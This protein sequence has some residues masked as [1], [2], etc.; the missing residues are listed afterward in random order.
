[1]LKRKFKKSIEQALCCIVVDTQFGMVSDFKNAE[2][3]WDYVF[4][5]DSVKE[6]V[7]QNKL[8]NSYMVDINTPTLHDLIAKNIEDY[9]KIDYDNL[10][11]WRTTDS[12]NIEKR[13]YVIEPKYIFKSPSFDYLIMIL[14]ATA[15][16]LCRSCDGLTS[17]KIVFAPMT[18][19]YCLD[20]GY[21]S[22][23]DITV[24][25]SDKLRISTNY[26]DIV[27]YIRKDYKITDEMVNY[28]KSEDIGML[29]SNIKS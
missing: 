3:E 6:L 23:N 18:I 12:I 4:L 15:T 29:L 26:Y 9:S 2:I 10:K 22:N 8:R 13:D 19:Q 24:P 20:K 1:M 21:L 16:N 28:Y 14:S 25:T 5:K 17:S 11:I 7:R 27:D